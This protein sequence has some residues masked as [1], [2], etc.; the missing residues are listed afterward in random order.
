VTQPDSP[1]HLILLGLM[2]S[3]KTSLGR[4]VADR[5]GRPLVDGDE[6]LEARTGGRSAAAVASVDGID[7]L[8]RIEAEIALDALADGRPAVI[9]PAASVV[10]V[11]HVRTAIAA[12]LVVWL[13]APPPYLAERALRKDH[14]PLLDL[15]DPVALF[16][17]QLAQREPLVLPMADLV[18]DVSCTPKAESVD[19]IVALVEAAAP[20][21]PAGP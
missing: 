2:G 10:E 18:I 14:R 8:H 17:A 9:G 11:E 1:R 21:A 7:A 15:G 16:T 20:K 19:R 6:R 3:G 5:T 12:H 13:T 4:R